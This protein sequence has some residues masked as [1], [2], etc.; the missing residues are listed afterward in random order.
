MLSKQL[1]PPLLVTSASPQSD[2]WPCHRFPVGHS[3]L[4]EILEPLDARQDK[5]MKGKWHLALS[6]ELPLPIKSAFPE[7]TELLI[8][9]SRK[10]HCVNTA[11]EN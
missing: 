11:P 3:A 1:G 10:Q 7:A 4:H 6:G 2:P 8:L 5:E 9:N